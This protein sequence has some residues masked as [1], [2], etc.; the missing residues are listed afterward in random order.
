MQDRPGR[1]QATAGEARI[2]VGGI[3]HIRE[4]AGLAPRHQ[5]RLRQVQER[6]PKH[7]AGAE[8][9]LGAH[10]GEFRGAAAGREPHQHRLGLIILRT[11]RQHEAGADRLGLGGEQ[12]ITGGAG[13]LL[14]AGAGLRALPGQDRVGEAVCSRGAAAASASAAEP[15]AA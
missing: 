2:R 7:D 4:A 12:G 15:G 1:A 6:T 10:A 8:H 11:A 14:Q 13:R 3:A 5:G 9:P